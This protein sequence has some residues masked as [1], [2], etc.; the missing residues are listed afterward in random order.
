MKRWLYRILATLA[1]AAL[2][3][4]LTVMAFPRAVMVALA[5]KAKDRNL[6]T[7]VFYHQPRVMAE[8]RTVIRP[9]PDLLYSACAYDVSKA[10]LRF[11]AAVPDTYWSLSFFASNTDN[12]FVI[13]DREVKG[14]S[15]DILLVGP[16]RPYMNPGNA[17]VVFSPS[18]RGVAIIRILI[19]HE[20][21]LDEL[22]TIQ[23]QASCAPHSG[24]F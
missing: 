8:S 24:G 17:Q 3:H 21:K 18:S 1:L 14:N 5:W 13:N 22:T 16:G 9:S 6:S 11:S 15:A 12:F 20:N 23:K 4:V 2:F 19:T 7:N 10:P